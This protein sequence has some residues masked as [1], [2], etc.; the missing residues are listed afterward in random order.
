MKR[1][2]AALALVALSS[3]S[4][5]VENY[6][7]VDVTSDYLDLVSKYGWPYVYMKVP[8]T[9]TK[10]EKVDV[11]LPFHNLNEDEVR[12]AL[13]NHAKLPPGNKTA[14]LVGPYRFT[15][16]D[17]SGAKSYQATG[18]TLA[19]FKQ[20]IAMCPSDVCTST[21]VQS[22]G[23][24]SSGSTGSSAVAAGGYARNMSAV[25]VYAPVDYFSGGTHYYQLR[26]DFGGYS[27]WFNASPTSV[28]CPAGYT[29]N[30][31]SGKCDLSNI[32]QA[33]FSVGDGVCITYA[34]VPAYDDP[35]CSTVQADNKLSTSTS[36][37]GSPAVSVSSS[38][39]SKV[40]TQTVKPDASSTLSQL[41]RTADGGSARSDTSIS[42]NGT[43]GTTNTTNYPAS[44]PPLYPGDPGGTSVPGSS[45]GTGTSAVPCGGP[46]QSA[47]SVSVGQMGELV[48]NTNSTNSQLGTINQTL[49]DI[50]TTLKDGADSGTT[51]D[52]LSS[53]ASSL[54]DT[55]SGLTVKAIIPVNSYCPADIF[56]F[57]LPLPAAAGGDYALSDQGVFCGLMANYQDLI[58]S[59]SI[60]FGLVGAMF[61]IL[62][63]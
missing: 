15:F 56:S 42:S 58:R 31:T 54:N 38:V 5:A 27:A 30:G 1:K 32:S 26:M 7:W 22:G 63:A 50:N 59:L 2:L 3:T 45:T 20:S 13:A 52:N 48:S 55:V 43:V 34:G 33:A 62:R 19:E 21:S 4:F 46:G 39:G 23:Y 40:I 16:R 6:S 37:D 14:E 41:V 35:D 36:A 8:V 10:A 53:P 17:Y 44:P 57:T 51:S 47:C 9:T 29:L 24:M 60:A 12:M 61:I 28:T 25:T 18:A 11:I 49:R